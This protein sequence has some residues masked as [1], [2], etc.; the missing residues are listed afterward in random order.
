MR[1]V[2]DIDPDKV[3]SLAA[4]GLTMEQIA[5]CVGCAP[6]TLYKHIGSEAELSEAIKRGRAKGVAQV[7]NALFQAARDGNITAQIFYL[8]NRDPRAWSDRQ[9][10]VH[11]GSIEHRNIEVDFS[12]VTTESQLP[13]EAETIN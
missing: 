12:D 3:E 8:K 10:T 13:T 11:T 5:H 7:S 4:Q 6:S 9:I 2:I 1:P